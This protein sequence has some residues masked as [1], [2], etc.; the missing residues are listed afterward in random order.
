MPGFGLLI[1]LA[2]LLGIGLAVLFIWMSKDYNLS[3]PDD[4]IPTHKQPIGQN[5]DIDAS[6][7]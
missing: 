6:E 5:Q 2:A 7:E 4:F 3:G 1:I